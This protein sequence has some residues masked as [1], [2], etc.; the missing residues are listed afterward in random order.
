MASIK[1]RIPGVASAGKG[2]LATG[3]GIA[4][5]T[6]T[7]FPALPSALDSKSVV[8]QMTAACLNHRDEYQIM[9]LKHFIP[10]SD[11]VGYV[12]RVG[13]DVTRVK[14]GD[15][16][17]P[18]FLQ[19]W[20]S[21]NPMPQDAF[22]LGSKEVPGTLCEQMKLHED[23]LVKVPS[24]LTDEEAACLP[25]AGVTAWN[26]LVTEGKIQAGETVL[27][28][29]TGGVSI[30]G[31]QFAKALGAKVICT[32]SSDSKLERAK[33]LGADHT[34]NYKE[35]P[36]WGKLAKKQFGGAD[37]ILE[38]GGAGT[39]RQ[40][41]KALNEHGSL[42]VIGLLEGTKVDLNVVE[43]FSKRL[44]MNGITVGNRDD[45]EVMCKTIETSKLKPVVD[46]TFNLQDVRKA[47]QYMHEGKHFG[48]IVVKINESAK[49]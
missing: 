23:N 31:L 8:L 25:C 29:G 26:G 9:S 10:C 1:Y 45:F 27:V 22:A 15:R 4:G 43:L 35:N 14:V 33:A 12:V 6:L 24:H 47:F 34:I 13:S 30:F 2:V 21:G 7:D 48:N 39:F 20:T 40:A 17:C 49:L 36:E 32:S 41:M 19:N 11:G 18:I 3:D 5:L 38:I 16:V 28:E 46:T 44:R 37:H 42:A